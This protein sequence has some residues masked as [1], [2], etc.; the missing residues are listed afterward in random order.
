MIIQVFN[1]EWDIISEEAEL[2][3]LPSEVNLEIPDKTWDIVSLDPD[4]CIADELSDLYGYCLL[5]FDYECE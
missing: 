5:G 3:K 2:L 4:D 1:I